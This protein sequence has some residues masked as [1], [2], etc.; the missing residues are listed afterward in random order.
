MNTIASKWLS[1]G[2]FFPPLE[3]PNLFDDPASDIPETKFG[4]IISQKARLKPSC[5]NRQMRTDRFSEGNPVRRSIQAIN[6]Q[7]LEGSRSRTNA[8]KQIPL[9]RNRSPSGTRIVQNQGSTWSEPYS[10]WSS[11]CLSQ[12][13][14]LQMRRMPLKLQTESADLPGFS[15]ALIAPDRH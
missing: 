11:T 7:Q 10:V 8:N 14:I 12:D 5:N 1:K 13:A 2:S 6:R 9:P 3:S 4:A 15:K